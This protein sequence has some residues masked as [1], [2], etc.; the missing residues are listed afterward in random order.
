MSAVTLRCKLELAPCTANSTPTAAALQPAAPRR[1][2]ALAATPGRVRSRAVCA[3]CCAAR[4]ALVLAGASK[5]PPSPVLE[6]EVGQ[7]AELPAHASAGKC[8]EP[9]AER[10]PAPGSALGQLAGRAWPPVRHVLPRRTRLRKCVPGA[11]ASGAALVGMPTAAALPIAAKSPISP[12]ESATHDARRCS[13]LRAAAAEV[14]VRRVD[15]PFAAVAT[16]TPT[17]AGL[18]KLRSATSPRASV[19]SKLRK[20]CSRCAPARKHPPHRQRFA[21]ERHAYRV[22]TMGLSA[23]CAQRVPG[24]VPLGAEARLAC[25]AAGGAR[26]VNAPQGARQHGH[27][28]S[29][30]HSTR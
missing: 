1:K 11:E 15:M 8:F 14:H 17:Q 22:P 30:T 3:F 23:Q 13:R 26:H 24:C 16:G 19:L 29:C 5:S 7:P 20:A 21:Q 6:A 10:M 28:T 2:T 27:C 12:G 18:S 25:G 4:A 9:C